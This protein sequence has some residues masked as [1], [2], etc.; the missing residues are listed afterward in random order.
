[1]EPLYM[2]IRDELLTLIKNQTYSE[3]EMIPSEEELAE[4]YGVSRPT[5]RRAVNLL[6][7]AGYL[8]RRPRHGTYVLSPKIDQEFPMTLRGYSDEMQRANRVPRTQ[9]I[10]NRK[11][12]ATSDVAKHLEVAEDALVFKLVRLRYVDSNPNVIVCSYIPLDLYP[13]IASVDFTAA[14]LYSYFEMCGNPVESGKRRLEVVK[15]DQSLSALLDMQ[16]GDPVYRFYT[17]ARAASGRV[18]EYSSASY[19]GATNAFEF[20]AGLT[21]VDN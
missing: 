2:L 20:T 6:V 3:G 21:R 15:A 5:A 17:V 16:Q 7:D 9:V 18:V 4:S 19:R 1:M 13:D 14:S 11:A 8:E 12:R 10:L